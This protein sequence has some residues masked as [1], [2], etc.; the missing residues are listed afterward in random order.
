[1]NA[2]TPVILNGEIL[3]EED[4]VF[5]SISTAFTMKRVDGSIAAGSTLE[6]I[7]REAIPDDRRRGYLHLSLGGEEIDRKYWSRVRPHPGVTV[8]G[9]VLPQGPGGGKNPLRIVV[10][11]ALVVLTI[12]TAGALAPLLAVAIGV[13]VTVAG[14]LIT[15]AMSVVSMLLVN[16]LFPTKKPKLPNQSGQA[17]GSSPTYFLQGSRNQ[18]NPF[19]VVPRVY[20][21]HRMRPPYGAN[22]YTEI[23]GDDQYLRMMFVWGMGPLTIEDLKIG[24]TPLTNFLDYE[25][26][27]RYGYPGDTPHTLYPADTYEDPYDIVITSTG[28]WVTRTS[29]MGADELSID[30]SFP[31]GIAHYT[32]KGKREAYQVDFNVE[33]RL[34]GSVGAWTKAYEE[35]TPL[36]KQGPS[37]P[38]MQAADANTATIRRGLRWKTGVRGQYDVRVMRVTPDI[39][40]PA[41]AE[42]TMDEAHWIALRTFTNTPP[43]NYTGLCTTVIRIRASDQLNG[44]IDQ[45]SGIVTSVLPDYDYLT[46][47]WIERPTSNA[48]AAYRD[49]LQGK[50][51]A[52]ALPDSKLHFDNLK[53]WHNKNRI[54]GREFNQVRDFQ[55]SVWDALTDICASGRASPAF[56]DGKW[57]VV[58]DEPKSV[59]AQ[60]FTPRNSWGFTGDLTYVDLPH[61][62]TVRFVNRN[63]DWKQ[64]ERTV[65]DDGY[66]QYGEVPGT[67]AATKFEG[68]ELPGVT[69]PD[70]IFKDART[71]IAQARLRHERY[72]IYADIEHLVC[73]RGD[74]VKVAHDVPAWGIS[75]GRVKQVIINGVT[76]KTT[77]VI[78]DELV[79]M[80]PA[81][82]YSIRFRLADGRSIYGGIVTAPGET[83]SVTFKVPIDPSNSPAAKDLFMA[84]LTGT[85]TSDAL[86]LGIQPGKDMTAKIMLMDYAPAVF[87]ADT[88]T[89]PPFN[90]N[91]SDIPGSDYPVV[92]QIRSDENVLQRNNDGSL[93]ARISLTFAFV[94]FRSSTVRSV[95]VQ[96]KHLDAD[97]TA[98]TILPAIDT[99][100]REAY[101]G[102]VDEGQ[103]YT[104]RTRYRL[105]NGD[106]GD[107]SPTIQHTVIGKSTK[108]KTPSNFRISGRQLLWN[109]VDP[110]LDLWGY[111]IRFAFG[112]TSNWNE[113]QPLHSN[114]WS[115]S[116]FTLPE[117]MSGDVT[118][119][120]KAIDVALNESDQPAVIQTG[121]GDLITNNVVE[122]TDYAARGFPGTITGGSV[123]GGNT[124]TS[125]PVGSS[126]WSSD[127]ARFWGNAADLFWTGQTQERIWEF[128]YTP[129]T[130]WIGPDTNISLIINDTSPPSKIEYLEQGASLAWGEDDTAAWWTSPSALYWTN[131]SYWVPWYGK[132]FGA[133]RS[134]YI[135]RVTTPAAQQGAP[136]DITV[137]KVVADVPD[138]EEK[139]EDVTLAAVTGSRLPITKT[140][141]RIKV[142][143]L[144]LQGTGTAFSAKWIDKDKDLGPLCKAFDPSNAVVLGSV[145]AIVQGY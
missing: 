17:L 123:S 136:T 119:M 89:I 63:K 60:H 116:P 117:T 141:R 81:K 28:G 90:S 99:G 75:Q 112:R 51:N 134:A 98:W 110:E 1:M 20:G 139:L 66:S 84:G 9:R 137:A 74:R 46:D 77:G 109:Y 47:T 45:L 91:I 21:R 15:T 133:A 121:L 22:P 111:Q 48:A 82:D 144:T 88:G 80:E 14:A 104:I 58:I 40:D 42:R 107:W 132:I 52:R 4:K 129:D 56:H 36:D 8:N 61:G 101:I 120:V 25:I 95:E 23:V 131:L 73:T 127:T 93:S 27:H 85:E 94:S 39:T 96:Y 31:R 83:Y 68:L 59:I 6:D 49:V 10:M 125:D 54:A 33:F 30:I 50:S 19:G 32:K 26:E 67:V 53:D 12:F 5:Y 142:V 92:S 130:D 11:L 128:S 100:V 34:A 7:A 16:A 86:V 65:Y 122:E 18:A 62:F 138:V 113:C 105:S 43:I 106:P 135:W 64:D 115:D 35:G 114:V 126:F 55:S 37:F 87:T 57:S 69:D 71:H 41:V 2:I 118:L 70:Y 103:T 3:T 108:P 124:L 140:Y 72:S 29:Q 13:S 38:S 97:E 24:E 79:L 44:V 145:D 78:L 102:N 143:N 76:G